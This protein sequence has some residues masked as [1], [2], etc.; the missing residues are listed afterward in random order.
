[1][2]SYL[3]L[4]PVATT[5][6]GG[7]IGVSCEVEVGGVTVQVPRPLVMID[8]RIAVSP[9]VEAADDGVKLRLDRW[10][11]VCVDLYAAHTLPLSIGDQARAV[12]AAREFDADPAVGWASPGE[13]ILAW[14][15]RWVARNNGGDQ[16]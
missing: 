3:K 16:S 4:M 12:A 2:T 11:P 6:R 7:I 10:V 9:V 1:M 5:A 15:H 13:D 14:C 8:N